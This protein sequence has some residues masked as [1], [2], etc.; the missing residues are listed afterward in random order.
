M[1]ILEFDD[2]LTWYCCINIV[3]CQLIFI[4]ETIQIIICIASTCRT[5]DAKERKHHIPVVDRTPVEPPPLVVAIVGPP[6]V[7]KTTLMRGIVKNFTKHRLSNITGP[8]TVVSG[9][10]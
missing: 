1:C 7:G 9:R 4:V 3:I 5:L 10:Y 2:S 8:V 6:K